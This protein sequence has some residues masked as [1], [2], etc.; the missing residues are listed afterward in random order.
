MQAMDSDMGRQTPKRTCSSGY[1]VSFHFVPDLVLSSLLL[2]PGQKPRGGGGVACRLGPSRR[3]KLPLP[4]LVWVDI[5]LLCVISLFNW[6]SSHF[7]TRT[8]EQH[9][10][11]E[12][13]KHTSTVCPRPPDPPS[14]LVSSSSWQAVRSWMRGRVQPWRQLIK[15]DCTIKI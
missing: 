4:C 3:I 12:D 15:W 1:D 9:V 10:P 8:N 2:Y 7:C 13:D 11:E 6:Q 5:F 14:Q